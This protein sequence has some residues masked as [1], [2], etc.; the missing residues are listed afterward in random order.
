MSKGYSINVSEKQIKDF[1]S[2]RV[3][4]AEAAE[5][6][7]C[8]SHTVRRRARAYGIRY[9]EF[10]RPKIKAPPR[11]RLEEEIANHMT[12]RQ[13]AEMFSCSQHTVCSWLKRY[14]II[15]PRAYRGKPCKPRFCL[16][17][18]KQ[19]LIKMRKYCNRECMRSHKA[20]EYLK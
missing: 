2:N 8:S 16:F 19:I 20:S 6:L 4:S 13:I 5:T 14:G 18:G 12:T 15:A 9:P 11:E 1:I 10:Y 17:C 3:S 7:G